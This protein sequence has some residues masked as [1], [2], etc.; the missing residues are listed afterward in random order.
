ML[1]A[2]RER[3]GLTSEE[4]DSLVFTDEFGGPLRY[5]NWRRRICSL[6]PKP[7]AVTEPGSMTYGG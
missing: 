1:T 4:S 6:R 2:H 3:Q 5:S 7:A